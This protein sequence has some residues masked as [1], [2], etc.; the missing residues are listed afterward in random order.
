MM[1]LVIETETTSVIR[2]KRKMY[3]DDRQKW[4]QS[5]HFLTKKSIR[6]VMYCAMLHPV[7]L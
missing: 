7:A 3:Y 2:L 1:V 6:C 4:K 5:F